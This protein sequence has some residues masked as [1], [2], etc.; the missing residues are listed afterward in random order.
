MGKQI[1]VEKRIEVDLSS[2]TVERGETVTIWLNRAG[3]NQRDCV[4]VE[5]RSN[6]SGEVEVFTSEPEIVKHFDEWNEIN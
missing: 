4:Q 1:I 6:S 3:K 5:L 2:I